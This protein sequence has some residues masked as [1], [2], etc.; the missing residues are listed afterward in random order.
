MTVVLV[1]IGC[2]T[3]PHITTFRPPD[4]LE[5]VVEQYF[6]FNEGPLYI[7][8]DRENIPYLPKGVTPVAIED[9]HSDKIDRFHAAYGH[10]I[11]DFW[12]VAATRFFYLEEFMRENDIQS[13]CHFDNDVLVYFNITEHNETFQRLYP[14][15]GITPESSSKS[16]AGFVFINS[17]IT[18]ARMTDFF[19][20]QLEHHGETGLREIYNTDTIH[21]ML[22]IVDYK[23]RFPEYIADLPIAPCG[24]HSLGV[25]EFRAI[26]DPLSWGEL[27][28]GTRLGKKVGHHSPGAY[29]VQW[30]NEHP[31]SSIVW[32]TDNGLWC[33]YLSWEG[34]LTKINNLH[35]HSKNLANFMSESGP[36][37]IDYWTRSYHNYHEFSLLE[38]RRYNQVERLSL[39]NKFF[40]EGCLSIPG[41]MYKAD[42]KALYDVI[43]RYKPKQ[44]FEIGTGHGGGSTFFLASAFAKLGKGKVITLEKD[45]SGA[46]LR[47]YQ[48]FLPELLPFVEFLI[49]DEPSLFTPFID[50]GIE[51][52]FLDGSDDGEETLQQYRF[53]KPHFKSG[54]ILVAH[55]WCTEKMRLLRP[56]IE[57]DPD[58]TIEVQ[59]EEP[60]SVGFIVARYR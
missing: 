32:R 11:Q 48:R 39:S 29:I 38:R 36:P 51:C 31:N 34:V 55:D 50:D 18:L 3:G 24:K 56:E 40:F 44:C 14:G 6:T 41:E 52:I 33:P 12:T 22:L 47:N 54:T 60:E 4:W 9:Y 43:I 13:V 7:L 1:H 30:L 26:F 53:F 27:V 5:C 28:D 17:Y 20:Y 46:A 42:R 16:P 45:T 8:T 35:L 49:G 19:I 59:L 23:K 21:E 58:W 57:K 15:I 37:N 25:E 2:H 10:G